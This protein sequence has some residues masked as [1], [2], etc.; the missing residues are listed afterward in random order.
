M[1]KHRQKPVL[2]YKEPWGQGK[3]LNKFCTIV[4]EV[5]SFLGNPVS[6]VTGI[7][8]GLRLN[9]F[10]TFSIDNEYKLFSYYLIL[11]QKQK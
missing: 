7:R 5:S 3:E 2:A 1:I 10:A 11:H 6:K 4:S 8:F 9:S